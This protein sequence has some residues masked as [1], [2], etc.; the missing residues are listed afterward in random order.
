MNAS[1]ACVDIF[2]QPGEF[3]FG[4]R[5]TRIRTVLGSCVSITM[6]HPTRLIGGMCHYLLASSPRRQ[7]A[8]LDGRYGEDAIKMFL[9]EAVRHDT[10]PQDYVFKI[11]GGG[12][13]FQGANDEGRCTSHPCN[14]AS[15]TSHSV[16]CRNSQTGLALL[17]QHG[18]NVT[19]EHLGGNGHRNVIFEIWSGHVWVRQIP[20]QARTD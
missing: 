8:R 7:I 6:W 18:L 2:L 19:A 5:D 13:M 3:Y 1:S 14:R 17:Q 11:F 15:G 16:S 20:L 12:S 4:E 9:Q 10:H